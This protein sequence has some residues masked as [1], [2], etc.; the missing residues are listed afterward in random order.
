MA[1]WSLPDLDCPIDLLD[2]QFP[3]YTPCYQDKQMQPPPPGTPHC[4]MPPPPP[5]QLQPSTAQAANMALHLQH[6]GT[7][8]D[9]PKGYVPSFIPFVI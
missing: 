8:S 7:S 6:Y 9:T 3:T 4:Q 2:Y 1:E 5:A